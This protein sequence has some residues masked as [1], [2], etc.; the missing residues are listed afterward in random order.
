[1]PHYVCP[2]GLPDGIHI[3]IPKIS[4]WEYFGGPCNVKCWYIL[5]P[6]GSFYGRKLWYSLLPFGILYGVWYTLWSFGI[7]YG[8]LV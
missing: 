4:I 2:A 7:L 5:M 8:H 3:C 6:F 1:M